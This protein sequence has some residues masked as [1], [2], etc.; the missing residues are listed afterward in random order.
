[1]MATNS[2]TYL[3]DVHN[4]PVGS[5]QQTRLE[6][7][8]SFLKRALDIQSPTYAVLSGTKRQFHLQSTKA[9]NLHMRKTLRLHVGSLAKG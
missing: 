9:F 3:I 5:C 8:D 6:G 1:M 7:L 4:A 2:A